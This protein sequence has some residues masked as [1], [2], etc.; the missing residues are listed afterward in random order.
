[1][2]WDIVEIM[3]NRPVE[4]TCNRSVGEPREIST[5]SPGHGD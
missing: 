4:I 5:R 1:M 3:C 2:V